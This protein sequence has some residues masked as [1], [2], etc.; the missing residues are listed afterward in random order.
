MSVSFIPAEILE[1]FCRFC[2]KITTNQL[3]RSIAGNGRTIDKNATFEYYCTKCFK[4]ACFSGNDL[5]EQAKVN[6]K[7]RPGLFTHDHFLIGE[8]LFHKKFKEAG[9]V[10]NKDSGTTSS[11]L[12]SFEKAGLKKLVQDI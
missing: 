5:L 8:R 12:V 4:T 1:V 9:L 11:V 2:G 10:V 3:E 7:E 6:G